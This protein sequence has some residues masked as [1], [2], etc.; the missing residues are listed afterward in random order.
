MPDFAVNHMTLAN[1]SFAA[2][3]DCAS[4]LG[5]VGIEVRNDL[6][7]EL[8]DGLS[9]TQAAVLARRKGLRILALAEI[10]AFDDFTADRQSQAESLMSIAAQCGAESIS[11]IPGNDG[12]VS[13]SAER[14]NNLVNV[15][16]A[17]KPMLESHKLV[18]MIE[19]LGFATCSLRHK[20]EAVSAIN[21][22]DGKSCFRIVHDTF[23]H[24]LA[25]ESEFYPEHTGIVHI[26]GVNDSALP[27][28]HMQDADRVLVD[29][30]DQLNNTSQ[31]S[32]LI[33]AGYAGPLSFEAFSPEI[34]AL[35]DPLTPLRGSIDFIASSLPAVAA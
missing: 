7:G 26:S 22:V 10:A 24:H 33:S 23:H 34:H 35:S 9:A 6:A 3:L 16:R 1:T 19:P 8:F 11:L 17:L 12:I 31:I 15:L 13:G 21:A 18:G 4:E 2:L 27:V 32:T 28:E 25:G 5:C 30:N 14:R 29:N 20:A